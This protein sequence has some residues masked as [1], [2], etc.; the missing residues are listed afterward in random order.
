MKLE[1]DIAL[2]WTFYII[3]STDFQPIFLEDTRSRGMTKKISNINVD[4]PLHCTHD[5]SKTNEFRD[6]LPV[7]LHNTS[8][9]NANILTKTLEIESDQSLYSIF[10]SDAD[11]NIKVIRI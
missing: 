9:S 11:E 6:D 10:T 7:L 2:Y 3:I 1:F 5:L 8:V 4:C